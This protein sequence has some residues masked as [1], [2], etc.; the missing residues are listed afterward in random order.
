MK[1]QDEGYSTSAHFV[2]LLPRGFQVSE[3]R[4]YQLIRRSLRQLGMD[5]DKIQ[6]Y[7]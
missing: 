4:I 6:E 7:V 3:K 2:S 1:T 5:L